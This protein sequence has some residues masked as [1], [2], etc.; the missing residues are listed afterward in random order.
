MHGHT[1]LKLKNNTEIY[2]KGESKGK[3][4][5]RTGIEGTEGSS[6]M[7]QLFI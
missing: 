2:S 4:L 5:P 6:G 1:N 3:V 7:V